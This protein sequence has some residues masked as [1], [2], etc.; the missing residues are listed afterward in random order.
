MS[1][2]IEVSG[3]TKRYGDVRALQGVNLS[4]RQGEIF[5]MLG[6]NGAGK[7]TTVEILEGLRSR[8]SG[9]IRVLGVDPGEQADTLKRKIGVALQSTVFP[10]KIRVRELIDLYGAL[11]GS[12][13]DARRWL[14]RFDLAE[15]INAFYAQLSG[16]QKQKLA[17]ILAM[18]NDPQLIFLDEPTNGLDAH[19]RRVVHDW[20]KELRAEGRT[21]FLT[22]HYIH[23]AEQLS[24]R[25]VILAK[26]QVLV[27]G[28]VEE[29]AHQV[30]LESE[31]R[32]RTAVP[33][34]SDAIRLLPGVI[35][36]EAREPWTSLYVEDPARAVSELVRQLDRT[37]NRLLDL[38][39]RRP[40]LEDLF[41]KMT[42]GRPGDNGEEVPA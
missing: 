9:E 28:T 34:D 19:T 2:I 23:E 33:L 37:G 16:G 18:V 31:V 1:H 22:T 27:E 10:E 5:A 29:L 12:T 38:Q 7:S 8:D 30:S 13:P 35:R 25:V 42:G 11:Y 21:V 32:V 36:T 41:L 26:G 14:E 3:L 4:V 15:K 6:P 17:L 20:L 24:D 39:V 40:T